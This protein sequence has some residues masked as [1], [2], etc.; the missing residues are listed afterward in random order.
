MQ[1]AV[2]AQREPLP[3]PHVVGVVDLGVLLEQRPQAQA[4]GLGDLAQGLAGGHRDLD[5][6]GEPGEDLRAHP[7]ELPRHDQVGIAD[8]RVEGHQLG[9]AHAVAAR[10]EPQVLPGLHR[11][12]VERHA[13]VAVGM[14]R[15]PRGTIAGGLQLGFAR[16]HLVVVGDDLGLGLGR[17]SGGGHGGPPQA[18]QQQDAPPGPATPDPRP[19]M[20]A[21]VHVLLCRQILDRRPRNRTKR[22]ACD[23]SSDCDPPHGAARAG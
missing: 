7:H 13:M 12:L 22:Q 16:L 3:H 15:G 21:V 20:L 8:L 1:P 14:G 6:L 10:D 23:R 5:R 9:S 18:R 11:V 2:D 17:G 4:V 19:P